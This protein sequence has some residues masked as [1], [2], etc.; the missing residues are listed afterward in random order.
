MG[1]LMSDAISYAKAG[2][3]FPV[4]QVCAEVCLDPVLGSTRDVSLAPKKP[5]SLGITHSQTH[6]A[7]FSI[8]IP[9][10]RRYFL[11][12]LSNA[13]TS[14]THSLRHSAAA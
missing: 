12:F 1:Q 14:K 5:V 8:P 13:A 10:H 7:R 3:T 6:P 11:D 9:P 4:P 2:R